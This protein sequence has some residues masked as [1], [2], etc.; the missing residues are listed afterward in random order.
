M[1]RDSFG[2][3][4]FPY[5]AQRF[6][7]ALFSRSSSYD[8][9]RI[10]E[11]AADTVIIELVERNISYIWRYLPV[12]PAPLRE[13]DTAAAPAEGIRANLKKSNLEGH[14]LITGDV[15]ADNAPL[16]ITDG[17][18]VWEAMPTPTGFAAHLPA[19]AE[20]NLPALQ[21]VYTRDGIAKCSPIEVNNG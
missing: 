13:V 12:F 5:L 20:G 21:L 9:S 10:D 11:C 14:A 15:A 17:S 3:N 1:F 18:A 7:K 6:G 2:N 8:L 16:Y 19:D 4:S